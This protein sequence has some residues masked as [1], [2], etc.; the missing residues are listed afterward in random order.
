M[1]KI[2]LSLA[3]AVL[4]LTA[5]ANVLANT[6]DADFVKA[7]NIK[8][9]TPEMVKS[10]IMKDASAMRA[11]KNLTLPVTKAS[12]LEGAYTWSYK[13]STTRAEDP[14]TLT[15]TDYTATVQIS[16][17]DDEAGTVKIT[18]MFDATITGKL[19]LTTYQLPTFTLTDQDTVAYATVNYNNASLS[20]WC[21]I[22]G[23]FYYS[24]DDNNDAGWYFTDPV[25]FVQN[26]GS[27]LWATNVYLV[28][29]IAKTATGDI[30]GYT[31]NPLWVPGSTMTDLKLDE[32][33]QAGAMTYYYE[34]AKMNLS[35]PVILSEDENYVVSV[36]N[37]AGLA[38]NPVKIT[39]AEDKTWKADPVLLFTNNGNNFVLYALDGNNLVDVTG[40]GDETKLVSDLDW[41]GYDTTTNYWIGQ[42]GAF[43]ITGDFVFPGTVAVKD[44][45]VDKAVKSVK[46]VS[47]MGQV[48]STPF[49]GVNIVVS[50]YEDGTSNAVKVMK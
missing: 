21:V 17:A 26:D 36:E 37:F 8:E 28:R 29:Q 23:L 43:T 41:T 46:Y 12:D 32:G 30:E 47:L 11:K 6:I 7:N 22:K 1:K 13:M 44:V 25:A 2:L 15:T 45:N 40:T 31:L 10:V 19:D 38:E 39:L 9:A 33:K 35:F 14:S 4:T 50:T 18:G 3:A 16:D 42:R 49:D 20:C 27:I 34:T 24:G 5:G 48:S